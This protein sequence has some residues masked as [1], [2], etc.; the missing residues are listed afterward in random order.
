MKG[1][2]IRFRTHRQDRTAAEDRA[3]VDREGAS[4]TAGEHRHGAETWRCPTAAGARDLEAVRRLSAG[5]GVPADLTEE[6]FS[7]HLDTAGL[8]GPGT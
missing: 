5:G 7:S 1:N 2:G 6:R 8:P 4:E 3:E